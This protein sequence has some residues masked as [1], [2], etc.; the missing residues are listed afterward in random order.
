MKSLK[1]A[2]RVSTFDH[3]PFIGSILRI[4]MLT[5]ATFVLAGLTGRWIARG[6]PGFEGT[7]EGTN[8]LGFLLADLRHAASIGR[9]PT[10]ALHLGIATLLL[11][12]YARTL[13]SLWYFARLERNARYALF[14]GCVCVVMTYILLLG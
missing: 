2:I 4:G 1:W 11:V 13:A 10:L 3:E 9:W 14:T 8:V 12:P 7:L 5:S 6:Q